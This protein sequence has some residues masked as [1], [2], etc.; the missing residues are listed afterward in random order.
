MLDG[1]SRLCSVISVT[2]S[3]S[4]AVGVGVDVG[5]T[6]GVTIDSTLVIFAL[7]TSLLESTEEH[8]TN[9][10]NAKIGKSITKRTLD[11]L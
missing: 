10:I 11:P 7:P 8:P 6:V 5:K 2:T 1:V 3:V 9:E 4:G